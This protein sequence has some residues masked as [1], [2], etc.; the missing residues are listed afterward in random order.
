MS[1][2]LFLFMSLNTI[3][4]LHSFTKVNKAILLIYDTYSKNYKRKPLKN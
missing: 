1:A 4:I 3:H 2:E